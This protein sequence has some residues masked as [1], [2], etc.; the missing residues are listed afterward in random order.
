MTYLVSVFHK[1]LTTERHNQI[2]FPF[3]QSFIMGSFEGNRSHPNP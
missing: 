2:I 1:G 3:S